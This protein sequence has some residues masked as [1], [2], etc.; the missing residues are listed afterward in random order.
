VNECL[1]AFPEDVQVIAEPGRFLVSDRGY[2]VCRVLGTATRAGKP[3]CTGTQAFSAAVIERQRRLEVPH[4][5][6]ALRPRHSV[7]RRR[8]DLRLGG[9]RHA[10]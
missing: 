5:H 1:K 8:A 6:R 10:R 7:D 4:P 3:G 2:F 9:H